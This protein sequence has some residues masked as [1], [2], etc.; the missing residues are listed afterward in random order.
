MSLESKTDVQC[1][2]CGHTQTVTIWRTLNADIS[3]DAREDLLAGRLNVFQC[4]RC[5]CQ[6]GLVVPLLYHDMGR[7]F[8]VQYH[9][10]NALD[11]PEF[12]RDY[13]SRGESVSAAKLSRM[14]AAR[15][16]MDYTA[17]VHVVFHMS[18]L[19][20]YIVFRERLYAHH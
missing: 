15:V 14:V 18:E 10:F 3:P 16:G 7:Q 11:D 17:R 4:E 1:P 20:R 13:D 6:V 9:P 8:M 2:K 5:D 12:F 19:V